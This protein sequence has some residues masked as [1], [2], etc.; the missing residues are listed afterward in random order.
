VSV[1]R[2]DKLWVQIK[3]W[4]MSLTGVFVAWAAIYLIAY[5]MRKKF[6]PTQVSLHYS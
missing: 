6:D 3:S 4:F 1:K 2:L 5:L